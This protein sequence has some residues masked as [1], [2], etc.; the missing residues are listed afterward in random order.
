M[1]YQNAIIE[2]KARMQWQQDVQAE[3]DLL[4]CRCLVAIFGDEFLAG[5]VA[6]R[7]GTALHK[8]YFHPQPRYSEDIDLVQINAGPIKPILQRLGEALSFMPNKVIK[9]KR[10][11]NT[12]LFRVGS[13]L[14]PF[15]QIRLKIEINCFE[16]FT[17]MGL[18][19]M[20]FAID[21]QWFS[22]ECQLTTYY[23][24]ELLGTKLRALYQRRKGRDLFDLYYALTNA[25]I[26][27]EKVLACYQRYIS[28]TTEQPPSYLQFINNMGEK[29]QDPEFLGDSTMIL[30]PGIYYSPQNAYQLVREALIE[31]LPGRR[32]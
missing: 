9:Q 23:L 21:N 8:L 2:W 16:H 17:E 24:E 19:K 6:F 12:L 22:G 13:E 7:G 4:L 10:Y 15:P 27:V 1:I 28:F 11:N 3:Q 31:H 20:P 25:K 30:R 29:M 18:V 32:K 5:H 26:D 14:P